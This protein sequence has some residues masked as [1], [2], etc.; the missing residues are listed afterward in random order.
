MF[1]YAVK[2]IARGRSIFLALFLSVALAATLFS[3]ILQGA[4][5]VGV[6]MLDKALE[7]SDVDIVSSAE[8]RNLTR[9]ALGKVEAEIAGLDH[10]VRVEHLIRSVELAP[11]LGMEVN[12]SGVNASIP[13]T[14]VAIASNSSLVKSI[15]GVDRLEP[16]MIY[17]EAGS[18]NASLFNAGDA[19]TLKVP[20]Y[21]LGGTLVDIQNRYAHF[22]VGGV[23]EIDDRLFSMAMGRYSLFL[24]S[25]LMGSTWTGRRPLHQLI[26]MSEETLLGWL[27]QIYA[28]GR[29]HTRP[30]I[31]EVIIGLDREAILNPWDIAGSRR[32]VRLVFEKVNSVGAR[33]GYVPVNYL[34]L[35]L[36]A[37]DA[38]SARM[39]TSTLMV[40]APVFFTAWYLGVTVSD[41]SLGLRRREIGLLFTR[42]LTHRQVFYIF[43]FE[44]LLISLFA[45]AAGVLLGGG[46]LLLVI[47]GM[48]AAQF[49]S[50]LSPVT[51]LASLAFSGALALLAVYKPARKASRMEIVDALR[52][53]QSEEE[54]G[55][56]SWHEP[57]LAL[58]LGAYRLAMLLLGV[59]VESFRP[60]TSNVIIFILYSTWWGVDYI[61]TYIAPILFF[62]GFIK[63]LVQYS[64]WF[65][66][67][68]G[69]VAGAL[70]GDVALFS[71]LSTR[72]NVRRVVA[73][74]FMATLI[75]SYGVSVI[76][77]VAST[78]DFMERAVRT[79]I[80][81]D[82][83]VWLFTGKGADD[84]AEEIASL[85]GVASAT[86]ETWFEAESSLGT[87][88]IR[89]IEPLKWRET[90]YMEAG[91]LEGADAFERMNRSET[92][93]L[94][95]KGAAE[96]L[97]IGLN[98]T[99]L[100]KLGTKVHSLTVVGLFGREPGAGWT[101]QNPT[102]YVPDAFL[103]KVKAKYITQTRILVDLGEGADTD[104]FVEAVEALD[105]DVESVDVTEE[106]IR[107]TSSNIFLVGPRRV[108]ELGVIFAALV[109]SVGIALI[110]STA[111]KSR[112]KELTIMAI[113]GFSQWQLA[114]TLLVE[115]IGMIIFAMMLGSTVGFISLRGEIEVFNAA[116]MAALERRVVFPPSA[117]L[118]LAAVM[119]LLLVSTVVPILVAVRR[120]SNNP[121]WRIE[122]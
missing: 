37:V 54:G 85:E 3:G 102:L 71:T 119:G 51:V 69:R 93:I 83:S 19:V 120:V 75:L 63:L 74:T 27:N 111:L 45:G 105:P 12:V 42:G 96:R 112:W 116:V 33:Y 48:R 86:V 59:S 56:G 8:N 32:A 20:T 104:A 118:S 39:K 7:A 117:Q 109:S 28:E 14:I 46:I 113:R 30:L 107:R 31:A 68:L 40:A 24:R 78:D 53:Y 6:A 49:L 5:A 80:G 64:P 66:S 17:V 76:G 70:V 82:A 9:T 11:D 58:V 50:S 81:A 67:L 44:A 65:H 18:V 98:G 2:R 43:L 55:A 29:R 26:I 47:P 15:A 95:E 110:T 72:R 36:D 79:T 84:L 90:A 35:L 52:E 88:P 10:V 106:L 115:N 38:N 77:S 21:V 13:F 1:S 4:D 73:A 108:E 103:A 114:A 41:V 94:M 23:V 16:G 61:L 62:W 99:M 101:L 22:T 87:I 60:A 97:G 34:G 25:V 57:L 100:I 122:E 92:A 121:M 89:A 91:W